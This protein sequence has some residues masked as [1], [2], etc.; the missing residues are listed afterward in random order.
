MTAADESEIQ[1]LLDELTDAWKRGDAK[2]YGA[3]FLPDGTFT[4]VN[5]EFYVGREEFDRRHALVF[6]GIFRATA[7]SLTVKELRFVRPDVAIADIDTEVA[8][9]QLRPPGVAVG[10]DG[11]LRSR[12]LMVLAK[13]Q[14]AWCIAAY[15]NVWQAAAA[16]RA[17]MTAAMT[18]A[19]TPG[20][21]SG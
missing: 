21:S 14:G 18:S 8:G 2:A 15:H 12:L 6:A 7:L 11:V 13:E 1:S 16:A 5:G 17:A 4:N 3:R 19:R 10:A 20:M 9:A